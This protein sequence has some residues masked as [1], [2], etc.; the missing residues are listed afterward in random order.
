MCRYPRIFIYCK[1]FHKAEIYLLFS[2]LNWTFNAFMN[3]P[4]LS[5][6]VTH[7]ENVTWVTT[8]PTTCCMNDA[9]TL[10]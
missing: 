6:A 8:P 4:I 9:L 3:L 2:F 7:H 5:P 1:I 10:L